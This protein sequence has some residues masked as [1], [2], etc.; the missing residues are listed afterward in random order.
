[1]TQ[2]L[3]FALAKL[4][5]QNVFHGNIRP[6]NLLM[7]KEGDFK[8]HWTHWHQ[9]AFWQVQNQIV[10]LDAKSVFSPEAL[11]SY[12]RGIERP[13]YN[14][15]FSD[16]FSLGLTILF[17]STLGDIDDI[18]DWEQMIV[19]PTR[20]HFKLSWLK[21]TYSER[22][23]KVLVRMLEIEPCKRSDFQSLSE[24]I[25]QIANNKGHSSIADL[26]SS[27]MLN[28]YS[29]SKFSSIENNPKRKLIVEPSET[30]FEPFDLL[31][32]T[33]KAASPMNSMTV[34]E[35]SHPLSILTYNSSQKVYLIKTSHD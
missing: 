12:H 9:T 30:M 18:F 3:I 7:T 29:T 6:K 34:R 1:M 11:D 22:L 26:S 14:P 24:Y 8:L 33:S 19:V 23:Y 32:K 2:K 21:A 10:Q 4:Q 16:V 15:L 20:I 13:D 25:S 35:S 28:A 31:S 5:Y 27:N 17:A